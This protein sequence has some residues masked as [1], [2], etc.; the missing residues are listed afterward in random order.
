MLELSEF[1]G[2]RALEYSAQTG[3][4]LLWRR[5]NN[6]PDTPISAHV[7]LKLWTLGAEAQIF[8]SPLD[9]RALARATVHA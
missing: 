2:L 9:R 8:C 6:A 4:Q 5:A 1:Q 7:A 3:A